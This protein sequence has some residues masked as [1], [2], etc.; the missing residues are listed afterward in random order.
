M[1][2]ETKEN[3]QKNIQPESQTNYQKEE[4]VVK[5]KE[6]ERP[7]ATPSSNSLMDSARTNSYTIMNIGSDKETDIKSD[8]QKKNNKTI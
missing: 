3:T 4:A 7:Y 2:F 8:S 5:Q 1:T 6:A